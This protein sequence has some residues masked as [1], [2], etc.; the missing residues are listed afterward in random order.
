MSNLSLGELAEAASISPQSDSGGG[1]L[2]VVTS[3]K[4]TLNTSPDARKL[5]PI[6]RIQLLE[7]KTG[8]LFQLLSQITNIEDPYAGLYNL[9]PSLLMTLPFFSDQHHSNTHEWEEMS[10]D[11][12]AE[13]VGGGATAT[14]FQQGIQAFA[15]AVKGARSLVAAAA[16]P[17][18]KTESPYK[19]VGTNMDSVTFN[20]N[21]FNTS[22]EDYRQHKTV[23]DTIIN[24]TLPKKLKATFFLPPVLCEYEIPGV[25]RGLIAK[26]E[27]SISNRGQIVFHEGENV[28]DAY[29]LSFTLTDL[30]MQSKNVHQA[31]GPIKMGG[32]IQGSKGSNVYS[33]RAAFGQLPEALGE[34]ATKFL[35]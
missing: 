10:L 28:P 2:D 12:L 4:W 31:N 32:N 7:M 8:Q 33:G 3:G 18:Y 16:I 26:L 35:S 6:I 22:P 30:V 29:N 25:R 21:L 19:W 20:F 17:G 9:E 34:L 15:G 13:S 23:V 24:A 5:A 14:T 11:T 27:I 1:G